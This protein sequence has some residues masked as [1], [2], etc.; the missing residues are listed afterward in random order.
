[1]SG[2]HPTYDCRVKLS[3][4]IKPDLRL[5]TLSRVRRHAASVTYDVAVNLN[6]TPALSAM[7]SCSVIFPLLTRYT[8]LKS[9]ENFFISGAKTVAGQ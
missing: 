3:M 5:L 2:S 9:L 8:P 4:F 1:M 6:Y 7:C